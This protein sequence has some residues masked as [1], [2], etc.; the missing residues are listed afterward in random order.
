MLKKIFTSGIVD[1]LN[2]ILHPLKVMISS[3]V[4]FN[5]LISLF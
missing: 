2:S 4:N 5:A 3:E 1:K